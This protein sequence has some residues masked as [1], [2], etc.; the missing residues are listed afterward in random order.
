MILKETA[1]ELKVRA[2]KRLLDWLKLGSQTFSG[3]MLDLGIH[4]PGSTYT[5]DEKQADRVVD[6]VLQRL[7][8]ARK[9]VYRSRAWHLA[10]DT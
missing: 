3:L 9:I 5:M 1:E 2:E 8:R 4:Q 10:E 7:R 6:S